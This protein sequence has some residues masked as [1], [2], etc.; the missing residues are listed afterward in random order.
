M[1]AGKSSFFMVKS[2]LVEAHG[3]HGLMVNGKTG[4]LYEV[5]IAGGTLFSCDIHRDQHRLI[6]QVI[7]VP[8]WGI[9]MEDEAFQRFV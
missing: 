8:W 3:S 5:L 9:I 1:F 2:P 6:I 7:R 4:L